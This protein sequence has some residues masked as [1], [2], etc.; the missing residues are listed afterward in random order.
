MEFNS[1]HPTHFLRE[2]GWKPEPNPFLPKPPRPVHVY[3]DKHIFIYSNQ[4]WY[5]IDSATNM[6]GRVRRESDPNIANTVPTSENTQERPLFYRWFDRY[7]KKVEGLLSAYI[8]KP[9]GVVRDNAL[10]E[11]DEKEM[12]LRMPDYWDDARL[13]ELV[14]A[15]HHYISTGALYEYFLLTLTSK[16]QLTADK[17]AQLEDDELEILDAANASKPGGMIHTLKPFG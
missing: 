6:M 16:D 12:W 9:Q 13:D 1:L 10:K 2:K 11:W 4:L 3:F 7:L 5:D 17:A 15:I 8:M 14:Q